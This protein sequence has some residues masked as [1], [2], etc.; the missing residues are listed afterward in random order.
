MDI[1]ELIQL[2]SSCRSYLNREVERKKLLKC[3]EAARLA[4][5]ATNAQPWH[6]YLV[7]DEGLKQKMVGF[8]QSFTK[9]AEFIVVTEVPRFVSRL[10]GRLKEQNYGQMD[11]GLAASY[12]ILQATELGLG[13]CI[14][15]WFKERNIKRLLAI[16]A[17]QRI[18][19]VISLGYSKDF[20]SKDKKR[21]KIGEILTIK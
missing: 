2:R 11:I 12:L 8:T 15:G 21:R 1:M 13:T 17:N 20:R 9:N 7:S 3:I 4:P 10:G 14:I 19:L 6:Y 16:P 18:R 5:S